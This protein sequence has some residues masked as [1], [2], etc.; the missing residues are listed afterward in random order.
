LS[1]LKIQPPGHRGEIQL[2]DAINTRAGQGK[3]Q[4]VTLK[5]ECYDCGS[6]MGYLETV[7]GFALDHP[8][9][10][11]RFGALMDNRAAAPRARAAE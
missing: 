8:D 6:E 1:I 2:A 4:A 9:Y 11:D 10:S 3:V 7:V 5:R